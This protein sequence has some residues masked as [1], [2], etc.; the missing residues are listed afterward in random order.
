MIDQRVA[1]VTGAS[2]LLGRQIVKA[3]DQA[4]WKTVGTGFT[5]AS[6]PSILKIDLGDQAA[7]ENVLDD[8]R[9]AASR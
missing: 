5:R 7:V 1:L 4:G 6:P 8:S 2:G 9:Y 3:F